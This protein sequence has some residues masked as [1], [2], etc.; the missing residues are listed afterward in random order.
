MREQS[1]EHRR[2]SARAQGH[3]SEDREQG[4]GGR[5]E[6]TEKMV[7]RGSWLVA[8]FRQSPVTSHQSLLPIAYCLFFTI[9]YCLLPTARLYAQT[10]IMEEKLLFEKSIQDRAEKIVEKITGSKE[11][12]V[13]TTVE[14]EYE[15]QPQEEKPVFPGAMRAEEDYLPGITYSYVPFDTHSMGRRNIIIRRITV[16]ITLPL[17]TAEAVVER[18]KK[19]TNELL[20]LNPLRGDIINIARI[21]FSRPERN[22]ATYFQDYSQ[23]IYWLFLALLLTLFLF[24]PLRHFFKTV[25]KAMELR[26]E[27]DTRIRS[28]EALGVGAGGPGVPFGGG[29]IEL[30]LD[31]KRPQLKEGEQNIMKRFGFINDSNLKNLLYLLKKEPPDTIAVVISYLPPHM[32]PQIL[33]SLPPTI[34]ADVAMNLASVK[35]LDPEQV[36][37][38]EKDIKTKIDYLL[39]GEENLMQLLDNVD[40]DAQENILKT[41]EMENPVLAAKLK[42]HMFFFEDLV[43][44][45]KTSVHKVLRECQR[46]QISMALALK[47]ASDELKVKIMDTLTEGAKAM[48]AEQIDLLGEVAEKRLMEERKLVEAVVKELEKNG[49]IVIDR[50]KKQKRDDFDLVTRK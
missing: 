21:A 41:L 28:A 19:E 29:P 47:N 2:Q 17:E 24:G 27:A 48:L 7:A 42:S 14:L 12:I 44:L 1:I 22:L 49:D 26:I 15:E 50:T 4:T 6:R 11:M 5:D 38:I 8:R 18:I 16:L 32:A 36:D 37:A 46:R 40:R 3:K 20:G 39:G 31:R 23:H 13:L 45:E 9:A 10:S 34:Q 30:T 35:I 43:V 25:V 33:G